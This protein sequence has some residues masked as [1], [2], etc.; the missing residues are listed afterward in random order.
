[1]SLSIKW[2]D[3]Q[4]IHHKVVCLHQH[5]A[6]LQS[7]N[8]DPNN[9]RL[10]L[11]TL[12]NLRSNIKNVANKTLKSEDSS[13]NN[14][15]SLSDSTNSHRGCSDSLITSQNSKNLKYLFLKNLTKNAGKISNAEKNSNFPK[16]LGFSPLPSPE[17]NETPS[18][19]NSPSHKPSRP[20]KIPVG[21]PQN[22]EKSEGNT[23]MRI[24]ICQTPNHE[25]QNSPFARKNQIPTPIPL[26]IR[27]EDFLNILRSGEKKDRK[28]LQEN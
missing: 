18:F 5:L 14:I 20:V 1:M 22:H 15:E 4:K 8:P 26:P 17:L 9:I 21:S 13:K 3:L 6:K 16:N 23:S 25:S 19:G 12:N 11:R 28:Y 7:P 10:F 2:N 27:A 24:E